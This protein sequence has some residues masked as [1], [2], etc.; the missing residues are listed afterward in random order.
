M[1]HIKILLAPAF[2]LL[3][4]VL[5]CTRDDIE[6]DAPSE[7]LRFSR[8]T[9]FLDTVYNQVR[10]ETY[11]VKLYN[12]EDRDIMIPQIALESGSSSLYR[13][14]MDGR[15]GTSFHN[16]P[17]RR[18]DSLYVFVEIAPVATATEAIAEDRI[19]V[20]TPAGKQHITLFSVVQD[21]EFFIETETNPNILTENTTWTANKAKIIF[22]N[23]KV[24]AGKTLQIEEGTKVYFHKNSGLHLEKTAK[25]TAN[26]SLGKEIIFRGDRNDTRY[27]TIP[28]N[29]N[30][31][32]ADENAT[33]D[34]N[35]T[36]IMG[37]TTGL[38]LQ[39]A[40][41]NIKNTI[42]HTH[43]EY[44]ILAINSVVNAENLVVNNCGEAGVGLF[45]GGTY[46]FKH[47]T[48][49]NYWQLNGTLPGLSLFASNE[50]DKE[51][52]NMTLTFAN[53]I[54]YGH[55][56]NAMIIKQAG[57]G[58]LNYMF[59]NI[60]LKYSEQAGFAFEGNPAITA[61]LKNEDPKFIN[62]FTHKMNLRVADDSPARGKGNTAVAASVPLDIA[63]QSRVNNPT[64][65][66]YQ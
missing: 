36:K 35:Y 47:A 11:A 34:L 24:A 64:L 53:S 33:V 42:I 20:E 29:W 23:L 66:A 54:L 58:N 17:L 59:N 61:S 57:S 19:L 39:K 14:N 6:F 46:N 26:G 55:S 32:Y 7:L 2:V 10:S 38:E 51:T 3:L 4:A 9:V 22:G 30:G 60:L 1:K 8:D 62:Y 31:I 16:V 40:Q 28:K 5:S 43:Q 13:I 25:L 15:A 12:T 49:A 65:G 50:Y 18:Q 52:G 37:G 48:L 56:N 21:A 27:D 44:G 63:Q 41:A 45:G